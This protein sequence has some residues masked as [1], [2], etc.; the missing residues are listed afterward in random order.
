MV[1]LAIIIAGGYYVK[2][3]KEDHKRIQTNQKAL[4]NNT[5]QYYKTKTGLLAASNQS[6]TVTVQELK[7]SKSRLLDT[8]KSMKIKD[9]DVQSITNTTIEVRKESDPVPLVNSIYNDKPAKVYSYSDKYIS[10]TGIIQND[11]IQPAVNV[12]VPLVQV[13]HEVPRYLIWKIIRLR[14]NEVDLTTYSP[15][16]YI[17]IISQ[18]RVEI[19][20][21]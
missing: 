16:P 20:R 6:L 18:E 1:L 8:I 10:L 12:I 11:S 13:V 14:A 21:K 2:D 19:R 9:R 4:L 15:N 7:K 17:T 3:L 5:V